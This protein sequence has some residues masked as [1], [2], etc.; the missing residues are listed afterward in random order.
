M[1]RVLNIDPRYR[2]A[3]YFALA[4][5]VPL[6]LFFKL[7][8]DGGVLAK[9]G[10]IAMCGFWAGVAIALLRRPTRPTRSDLVLV[11]GGYLAAIVLQPFWAV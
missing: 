4:L 10:G 2:D 5:Q 3:I 6:A 7:L 8:L 1:P 9:V 11:R